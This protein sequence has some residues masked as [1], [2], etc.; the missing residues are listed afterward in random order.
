[1]NSEIL[2]LINLDEFTTQRRVAIKHRSTYIKFQPNVNVDV[3][4][5]ILTDESSYCYD[6]ESRNPE[7]I[8]VGDIV[9]YHYCRYANDNSYD[10]I[11]ITGETK[12]FWKYQVLEKT[13]VAYIGDDYNSTTYYEH[14]RIPFNNRTPSKLKITKK[15]N[16]RC[17]KYNNIPIISH[18]DWYSS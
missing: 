15:Y 9:Y 6:F 2:A 3:K 5:K 8:K 1:M 18:S 17:L 7:D 16:L 14:N 4:I 11:Q 10:I 13:K 12:A